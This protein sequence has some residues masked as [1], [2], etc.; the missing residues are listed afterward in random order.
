LILHADLSIAPIYSHTTHLECRGYS[1]GHSAILEGYFLRLTSLTLRVDYR[2]FCGHYS[3]FDL[4]RG[5][6][7]HDVKIPQR[8]LNTLRNVHLIFSATQIHDVIRFRQEVLA[9]VEI[10]CILTTHPA[11]ILDDSSLFAQECTRSNVNGSDTE[12]E[13]DS[14]DKDLESEE[15]NPSIGLPEA[16]EKV[17]QWRSDIGVSQ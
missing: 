1:P 16:H 7:V 10:R 4:R 8:C 9:E 11:N 6:N 12:S 2:S 3:P 14:S 13:E 17:L 5:L 15:D